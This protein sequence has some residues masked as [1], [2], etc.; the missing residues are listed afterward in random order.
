MRLGGGEDP[1][2][3]F[4]ARVWM[5]RRQHAK[6]RRDREDGSAAGR[7]LELLEEEDARGGTERG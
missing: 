3:K 2:E 4:E 7:P 6:M 5:L 1:L